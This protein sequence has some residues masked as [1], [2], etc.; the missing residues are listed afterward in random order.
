MRIPKLLFALA[1]LIFIAPQ[2]LHAQTW[3]YSGGM[4]TYNGGNVGIGTTSPAYP[5]HIVNPNSG[6]AAVISLRSSY[7]ATADSYIGDFGDYGTI[8]AN[9]E[10]PAGH[11]FTNSAV[12]PNQYKAV[13]ISIGGYNNPYMFS[14]DNYPGEALTERLVVD[15]NGN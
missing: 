3:Q 12:A 5:L 9:N 13:A 11:V 4:A 8:I 1:A 15:W 2:I 7:T 10:Y 14:V 6:G